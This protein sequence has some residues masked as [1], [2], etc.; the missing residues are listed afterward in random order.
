VTELWKNI[1]I[2][3]LT[4]GGILGLFFWFLLMPQKEILAELNQDV[5]TKVEEI[6]EG[7]SA[8]E[9]ISRGGGKLS[10]LNEEVDIMMKRFIQRDRVEE[11]G[12]ELADW[13]GDA[14]FELIRVV[15]PLKKHGEMVEVVSGSGIRILELPLILEMR[16]DY[17][18]YGRLLQSIDRFPFE[19]I[20]GR[21][22]MSS[23]KPGT[24][25]VFI[26][27]EFKVYV[28]EE[29]TNHGV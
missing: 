2:H 15:P 9:E 5:K 23:E 4:L 16:G 12:M 28:L 24:T 11:V 10:Q 6:E 3:T 17:L 29:V 14:G 18:G 26:E 20:P 22:N 21:L 8:L 27:S 1:F 7:L 19:I 25:R 13:A